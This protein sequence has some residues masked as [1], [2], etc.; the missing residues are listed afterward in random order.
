MGRYM[1]SKADYDLLIPL[2]RRPGRHACC[3]LK[4]SRS[5]RTVRFAS[6]SLAR[7][8]STSL[9]LSPSMLPRIEVPCCCSSLHTDGSGYPSPKSRTLTV[10]HTYAAD[11][12]IAIISIKMS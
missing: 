12:Q 3:G 5:S 10:P 1:L 9:T 8:T 6:T 7:R 11:A 4:G 2:H